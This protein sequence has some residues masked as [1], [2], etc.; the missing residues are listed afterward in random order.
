MQTYR[1]PGAAAPDA[2]APDAAA[3]DAAIA[4]NLSPGA[5]VSWL[6]SGSSLFQTRPF[7][8][9]ATP[10][11]S[12]QRLLEQLLQSTAKTGPSSWMNELNQVPQSTA[13]TGHINTT[14]LRGGED[15]EPTVLGRAAPSMTT[16]ALT[17]QPFAG[18]TQPPPALLGP[19]WQSSGLPWGGATLS[20][21]LVADA[22]AV[23]ERPDVLGLPAA[24]AV[25]EEPVGPQVFPAGV[26]LAGAQLA[27]APQLQ[28]LAGVQLAGVQQL[29]Q[30]QQLAGVPLTGV[31]QL[32]GA[33]LTGVLQPL[34]I[35]DPNVPQLGHYDCIKTAPDDLLL[36]A[37]TVCELVGA[38][39]C[40]KMYMYSLPLAQ[41][42]MVV[43]CA[44]SPRVP[45]ACAFGVCLRR[46]PL[47]CALG[48]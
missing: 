35:S 16:P 44:A 7:S 39:T 24:S 13:K 43:L 10:D 36:N 4:A 48:V 18:A 42:G 46:V 20:D 23:L 1:N 2:A 31:Q 26:Q 30:L 45:L 17:G 11:R 21:G 41:V 33:P 27:G 5:S 14:H 34:N 47:A 37:D 8:A 6:L 28:Q 32:A 22:L 19:A 3:P 25:L 9:H 38:L 29:Q 40:V 15:G 12:T